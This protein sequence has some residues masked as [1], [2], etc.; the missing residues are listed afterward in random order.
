MFVAI[1]RLLVR[2]RHVPSRAADLIAVRDKLR[3]ERA[4][5]PD[6]E[7]LAA[8]AKVR[9]LKRTLANAAGA[10]SSCSRC[11]T[12]M[13][14]PGG[15]FAGGF[16][17]SASTGD[18]FT[19]DEVA[20]LAQGGTRLADLAAPRS[21]HAGCAFRGET[22]CT[23]TAEDRPALCVRFHCDDLRRELHSLGRLDAIEEHEQALEAAYKEF[24]LLRAA[25]LDRDE[26]AQ[27]LAGVAADIKPAA[28]D[29]SKP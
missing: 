28:V 27:L 15:E 10:V 3:A 7:E 11:G 24:A 2:L 22:G 29:A 14:L 12:G 6:P 25:R 13:P 1:D 17:C 21:K 23:L 9:R 8:A 18:L 5:S 4:A 20:L 19:A 26:L 16:C